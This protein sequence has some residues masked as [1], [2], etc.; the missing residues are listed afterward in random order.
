M[1]SGAIP[2]E[3]RYSPQRYVELAGGV[4]EDA[5]LARMVVI[6]ANTRVVPAK[7]AKEVYPGDVIVVPSDF[8]MRTV[9]SGSGYERIIQNL[10]ALAAAIL[11]F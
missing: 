1:R 4:A 6:R 10:A 5:N 7:L 9:S 8:L 2:Y 3:G 11:I